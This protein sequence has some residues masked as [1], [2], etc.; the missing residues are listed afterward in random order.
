MV[1]LDGNDLTVANKV[2]ITAADQIIELTGAAADGL[3]LLGVK[4]N[5]IADFKCLIGIAIDPWFVMLRSGIQTAFRVVFKGGL[6][7]ALKLP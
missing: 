1:P 5:H 2:A 4:S 7:T 3:G 6:L